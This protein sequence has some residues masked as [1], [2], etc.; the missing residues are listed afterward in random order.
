M[1]AKKSN[2]H[3]PSIVHIP[4]DVIWVLLVAARHTSKYVSQIFVFLPHK[5]SIICIM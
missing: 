4:T 5:H 2:P 3:I 1:E